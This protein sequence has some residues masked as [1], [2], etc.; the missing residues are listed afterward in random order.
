MRYPLLDVVALGILSAALPAGAQS[1]QPA[2]APTPATTATP[3]TPAAPSVPTV[4]PEQAQLL[5]SSEAFIR[6]L[7][8]WGTDFKVTL[9]PLSSS[10]SPD[11]YSLP[12]KVTINGQNDA[13]VFYVSKDGKTFMR[14]DVYDMSADP[15]AD[16]RAKLHPDGN[17]SL[18]PADAK[19]TLVEF[20][21]FECPHCRQLY[22]SMKV[23]EPEYPTIRV[24]FKDFPITQIHPWAET[25]AI[26]ARCAFM[27][28]PDS[29]WRVH[30]SI[31]E[32]QDVI[33]TENVWDKLQ[34]FARQ[35]GL[36]TEAFKTCMTAPEARQAVEANQAEGVS[37]GVNSTPTVFVNGRPA[38]GGEKPTL[39]QYINYQIQTL[40]LT[41]PAAAAKT[42]PKSPTPKH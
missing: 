29:F 7:F 3:S 39:V 25:A 22:Q 20:S 14:G 1:P 32:S 2:K 11:F 24:V 23:L 30:D 6:N 42:D 10:P 9:G 21:D 19:I 13:G 28:S 15:F 4:T 8:S 33:S 12:I 16:N 17:P 34:L 41:P 26:G 35:A 36:D 38:I 37:L 27:Q 40:H 31:F 5:K 18:G